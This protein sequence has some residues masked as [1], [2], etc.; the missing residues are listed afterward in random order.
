MA[1]TPELPLLH[2]IQPFALAVDAGVGL[3]GRGGGESATRGIV[4]LGDRW[5]LFF[6]SF[7]V[8]INGWIALLS[9][10]IVC[11]YGEERF[12]TPPPPGFAVARNDVIAYI[13]AGSGSRV[14]LAWVCG[15]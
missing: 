8:A 4:A 10:R 6:A 9:A 14:F 13:L 2:E 12:L 3:A 15:V 1:P 11:A 7:F 5:Q